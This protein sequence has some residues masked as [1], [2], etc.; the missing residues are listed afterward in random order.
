M[1]GAAG[2]LLYHGAHLK[3]NV[4]EED[5]GPFHY[6]FQPVISA[7][8]Q[9]VGR[10]TGEIDEML[11]G[12]GVEKTRPM[13]IYYGDGSAQIGLVVEDVQL[14]LMLSNGTTTRNLVED[15]YAVVSFPWKSPLSYLVGHYKAKVELKNYRSANGYDQAELVTLYQGDSILF[16][17]PV[18]P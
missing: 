13:S 4:S 14:N 3:V 10:I 7:S 6:V 15:R 1:I 12:I 11:A 17:Q 8:H 9:S 16:M 18:K 5:H 2:L